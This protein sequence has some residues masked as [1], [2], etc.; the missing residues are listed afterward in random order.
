MML[1]GIS[2]K[3]MIMPADASA[4]KEIVQ[5][6]SSRGRGAAAP[7]APLLTMATGSRRLAAV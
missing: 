1:G 2:D 7:D 6:T 5:Q 4:I 3:T